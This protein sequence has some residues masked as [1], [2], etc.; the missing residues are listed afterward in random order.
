MIILNTY[1][2]YSLLVISRVISS[3]FFLILRAYRKFLFYKERMSVQPI[4]SHVVLI[5]KYEIKVFCQIW[6]LE[7]RCFVLGREGTF[8]NSPFSSPYLKLKWFRHIEN[9]FLIENTYDE[10]E[11][12]KQNMPVSVKSVIKQWNPIASLLDLWIYYTV[13]EA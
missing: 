4:L 3:Q 5:A 11:Y 7:C 1:F 9:E 10:V 8:L 6:S 13:A 12:P 2:R